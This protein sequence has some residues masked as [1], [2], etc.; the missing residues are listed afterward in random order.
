[1][2]SHPNLVRIVDAGQLDDGRCFLA[3]VLVEGQELG[4]LLEEAGGP[5]DPEQV[6][7]IAADVGRA[8][9]AL[10]RAGIVHRDVKPENIRVAREGRAVLTDLGLVRGELFKTVTRLD[11]AV[12]TPAYMSPEQ[13]VG[14]A[15]DGRSDLWA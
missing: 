4:R 8:L 6:R 9:A 5:L 11:V 3:M 12:G 15:M 1:E 14:H 10:D 13:C 2:I 7:G